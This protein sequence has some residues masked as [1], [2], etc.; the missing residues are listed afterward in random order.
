MQFKYIIP[1]I[2]NENKIKSLLRAFS[3]PAEM[4]EWKAYGHGHIN[5]TYLVKT[6]PHVPDFILQRKNHLVF[7]NVP[8]M[9][10]NIILVTN[11]IRKK[12]MAAGI[13][14]TDRKVMTYFSDAANNYYVCDEDGNYWTLF[15]FVSDSHGI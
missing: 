1:K 9:M 13:P 6:A 14:E 15:L 8:G 10:N 4:T 2:M 11:H 3:L 12:L 7:R 5:D